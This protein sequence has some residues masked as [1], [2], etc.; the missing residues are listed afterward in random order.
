MWINGFSGNAT[1]SFSGHNG[2]EFSTV[3]NINDRAPKCCP[4]AR[5]YGGGW[6]FHRYVWD[7]W[8]VDIAEQPIKRLE[9]SKNVLQKGKN[10]ISRVFFRTPK[11]TFF[12]LQ[13]FRIQSQWW[14]S[15]KPFG[16]WLLSWHYLGIMARRLFPEVIKNDDTVKSFSKHMKK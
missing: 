3:D 7:F 2:S 4:C 16:Q 9:I 8:L 10:M 14:I 6:W 1:D 12:S 11:M 13:L 15:R 5:A